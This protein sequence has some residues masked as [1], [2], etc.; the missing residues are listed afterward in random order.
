MK[1]SHLQLLNT[2]G[3][4]LLLALPACRASARAPEQDPQVDP[5]PHQLMLPGGFRSQVFATGV[6]KAR[7]MVARPN[8]DVYVRLEKAHQGK[9]L[10]ALR[11]ADGDG[12]AE[13]IRYFG[14]VEAGSGLAL[15]S[16]YLYYATPTEVYRVALPT[17]G[18][19]PTAAPERLVINLGTEGMHNARSLTLDNHNQL[20]VN[21]GAPNNSC[22]HLDRVPGSKG[23]DPCPVLNSHA[24]IWRFAA[25]QRDQDKLRDGLHFASGIRNAVALEWHPLQNQLY[26]LQHGMDQ[27]H[28][29]FPE[30][31]SAQEGAELPAEEFVAIAQGDNLGWPYC[32]YDPFKQLKLLAPE[33]GGDGSTVARCSQFKNPL[34]ALPAHYAPNDLFFYTGSQFPEH[35]RQGAYVAFH[36]SWNRGAQQEGFQVVYIPMNGKSVGPWRVFA[37]NF[38]DRVLV[39]NPSKARFRPMGLA[40]LPDGALLVVDSNQGR[41]WKISYVGS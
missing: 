35:Y 18:L 40:Q 22:Q 36:G 14:E 38:A 6:G 12:L 21:V 30:H 27:L 39:S 7:H 5:D 8:G 13:Q 23:Q 34:L 24:G 25:D 11:D 26:L 15:D 32:Y 16:Q 20:Y 28:E 37:D 41:I 33:Y 9:S 31:F 17:E 10:V 4:S 3:L 1:I 29:S 2:L 19:V